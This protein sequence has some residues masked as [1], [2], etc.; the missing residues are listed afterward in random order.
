MFEQGIAPLT[1][2]L[3]N[4]VNLKIKLYKVFNQHKF[5]TFTSGWD[6]QEHERSKIV[7]IQQLNDQQLKDQE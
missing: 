2:L 1:H 6:D 7:R 3:S 5:W 4:L